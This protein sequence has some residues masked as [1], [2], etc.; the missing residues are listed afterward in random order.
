M[1]KIL[2]ILYCSIL[3]WIPLL[4]SAQDD[5]D[6][7]CQLILQDGLYKQFSLNKGGNFNQDL[8]TYFASDEFR[9]DFRNNKWGAKLGV[10]IEGVP[11]ELGVSSSD[12]QLTEFQNRVR[13]A[14]S[15]TLNQSFYDFASTIIPDV[16]LAKVYTECVTNRRQYGFKITP[17]VGENDAFFVINY[18]KHPNEMGGMPKVRR[19]ELRGAT[20]IAKSFNVGEEITAESSV[21][22]DRIPNRDLVL[23][24]ETDRGVASHRV[25]AEPVGFNKDFPVGTIICSYL[26]WTEFQRATQNNLTNPDGN[27][28]SSRYSKWAPADGRQVP[29]SAFLRITSQN[30]VPDLRG[31]FMRGLNQFDPEESNSVSTQR[32][33]P[34]NR[35]RGSYQTDIFLKH[36][37]G[38]GNHSHRTGIFQAAST[39]WNGVVFRD[40]GNG[41]IPNDI[42]TKISDSGD[43][44]NLE[45]GDETRPK[46]LA[47][48]Y[49]IRIN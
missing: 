48:Y 38:G 6:K 40:T 32:K 43:I 20:N 37:H 16:E 7:A 39:N 13:N 9:S 25:P 35:T 15:L 26:N 42:R 28:W 18:N 4:L 31:I 27:I 10:V 2:C 23:I 12:N 19:F 8:K 11:I 17:R 14:S 34:D 44:I 21:S 33:D 22:A 24:L 3:C 1:D 47:V 30:N 36:N 46:N 41:G 29:N 5:A 45:G 49:Y